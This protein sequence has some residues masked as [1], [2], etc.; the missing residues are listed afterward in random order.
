MLL[1]SMK[2]VGFCFLA[3]TEALKP[4]TLWSLGLGPG[5]SGWKFEIGS[6]SLV[7]G[8]WAWGFPKSRPI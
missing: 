6:S 3:L 4:C 5:C 2:F 1:Y 8:V 7:F